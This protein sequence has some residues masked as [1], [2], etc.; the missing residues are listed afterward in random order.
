VIQIGHQNARRDIGHIPQADDDGSCAGVQKRAA[1]PNDAFGRE[2]PAAS[3][4]TSAYHHKIAIQIQSSDFADVEPP[5]ISRV[6]GVRKKDGRLQRPVL[7]YNAVSSKVQSPEPAKILA[8][9]GFFG[10]I[11]TLHYLATRAR[12]VPRDFVYLLGG[13]WQRG[14]R[15]RSAE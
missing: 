6:G 9:E 11:A 1:Q 10:R 15:A 7:V 8:L 14:Q 12:V 5:V 2:Q 3:A 13:V 4:L